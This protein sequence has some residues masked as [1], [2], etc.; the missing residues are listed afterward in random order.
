MN[1]FSGRPGRQ[2]AFMATNEEDTRTFAQVAA[3]V[4]KRARKESQQLSLYPEQ[5]TQEGSLLSAAG[6]ESP[7][8]LRKKKRSVAKAAKAADAAA[9]PLI[10][11]RQEQENFGSEASI[12]NA[13]ET[14][15]QE[16]TEEEA[17]LRASALFKVRTS[18]AKGA[19]ETVHR[20]PNFD[21]DGKNAERKAL[22]IVPKHIN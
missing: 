4:P 9:S 18:R 21:G 10:R 13:N 22:K 17:R 8:A 12:V 20:D 7:A 16:T 6:T 5:Q 1:S 15:E 14:S 11:S 2:M 3:G 19:Q